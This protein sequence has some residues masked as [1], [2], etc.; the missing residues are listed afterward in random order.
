MTSLP[1]ECCGQE[2]V[3]AA[4]VAVLSVSQICVNVDLL[5]DPGGEMCDIAV[6]ARS[7]DFTEAHAAPRRQAEQRPAS[8]VLTYQRTAAVTLETCR[9]A[10]SV[11]P[12]HHLHGV[13]GA[14]RQEEKQRQENFTMQESTVPASYPAQSILGVMVFMSK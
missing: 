2:A 6:N 9:G 7:E 1:L 3:G 8:V 10:V 12:Q 14:E 4:C 11:C 13:P 5:L